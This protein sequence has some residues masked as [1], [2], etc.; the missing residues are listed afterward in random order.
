M[1]LQQLISP[2][3]LYQ[4]QGGRDIDIAGLES[5]SRNV[6]TG[7]LFV[8]LP[9]LTVDGHDFADQA[10][11]KGAAAVV[12]EK[13][14]SLSVPVVIVPSARRAAAVLA[15][16]FYGSPTDSFRLIGV[17]GTNGKTT[18]THMIERIFA[19]AGHRTGLM[20]TIG[21]KIGDEE[22]SLT[23]T[24][25]DVL[26][27]QNHFHRMQKAGASYVA[28]EVS[29]HALDMGRVWGSRFRTAV[30]TNLTQDH[31]DY[32][33][34]MDAYRD[35]KSLLF[36]QL[37]NGFDP[38]NPK[39]A[40]LNADDETS[41]LLARR[42][43]AQVVTYGIHNDADVQATSIELQDER[44]HVNVQTFKGPLTLS[45]R[46]IGT[47]SVYNT[48]AAL[49]V[50]LLEGLDRSTIRD[51]LESMQGVKGRLE[52]IVEG[53]DFNVIVD[54]AHTPDSLKNVLETLS[55]VASGRVF[56]VV[57]C[58]G[59]R[60]RTKRPLMAQTALAHADDVIFTSDN[61]RSEDPQAI[62]QDMTQGL[63]A[64]HYRCETD[65]R[66]AIETAIHSA[67]AGDVVIIAGKGH[68]TSQT[69]GQRML[70]F[71]DREVARDILR[72]MRPF[73]NE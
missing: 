61:P 3:V 32:H 1:Q 49:T 59:D 15:D 44:T 62:L 27:L 22:E 72:K 57:G 71:D 26:E 50:A 56:C 6:R 45:L 29:S 30:F 47:F 60:D 5:D 73:W 9:G 23:H 7:D 37:G 52:R 40:V 39:F 33:Q 68:E 46:M 35:A 55:H 58:G 16:R 11:R 38:S 24:T 43:A 19:R 54:Y 21:R 48:L 20:G 17:T 42:T 36:S 34:T 67:S 2:L 66:R 64:E 41:D 8:C 70:P 10:V 65:R 51:S 12:A 18:V 53:Q 31:L 69:V 63:N 13:E 4:S 25:P 28:M 14:L